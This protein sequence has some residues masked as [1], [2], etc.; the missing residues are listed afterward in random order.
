MK[1]ILDRLRT[2]Y[3]NLSGRERML[4][5]GAGGLILL[6]LVWALLVNPI[7]AVADGTAQRADSADQQLRLMQRLHKD[8]D[9]VHQRL[10]DVERRIA[11]GPRG[12]LRSTLEALAVSAGVTVDSMEPQASPAH[13]VYRETKVEVALKNITLPQ[14]VDYLERVE[15]AP[16]VLSIKTL[17]VRKRQG[18][19]NTLDVTFTVSSF[20]RL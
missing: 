3:R 18:D 8:F 1:E 10:A 20:E 6:A 12:N 16:Q 19:S 4:V 15:G 9:D 5:S 14:L 11:E 13:D 2:A 7:L 17:R